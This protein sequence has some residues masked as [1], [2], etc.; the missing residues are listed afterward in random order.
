MADTEN[1]Q[2]VVGWN[3][4]DGRLNVTLGKIEPLASPV[5]LG[6]SIQEVIAAN[7]TPPCYY[8][9]GLRYSDSSFIQLDKDGNVKGW[10]GGSRLNVSIE[11]DPSAP[12]FTLGSTFA[13]VGKAM[14]TPDIIR[15]NG[16]GG[17]FWEYGYAGSIFFDKDGKV[18]GWDDDKGLNVTNNA[19]SGIVGWEN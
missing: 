18:T 2:C 9:T 7:G 17:S 10:T 16:T 3:N 5:T 14:G 19:S 1:G 4:P 13:E 15:E 12:P 6:S 8:Y 11:K